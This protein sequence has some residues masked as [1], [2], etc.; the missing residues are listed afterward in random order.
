MLS[1]LHAAFLQE[2]SKVGVV[3]LRFTIPGSDLGED[4]W[5]ERHE[6]IIAPAKPDGEV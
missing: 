2:I 6:F 1:S 4:G 5:L 3:L